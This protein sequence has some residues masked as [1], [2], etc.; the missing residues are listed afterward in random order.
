MKLDRTRALVLVGLLASSCVIT[1]EDD[2]DDKENPGE[3]GAPGEG[4]SPATT[5]GK[6]STGG[7][8]AA[9]DTSDGGVSGA[10]D[11]PSEGGAAGA[12]APSEEGGSGG[13]AS[14]TGGTSGGNSGTGGATGGKASSTGGAPTDEGLGGEGGTGEE[15]GVCSDAEG[16]YPGCEGIT[17]DPSC[18]GLDTFQIGKCESAPTYFKPRIA[19]MIQY[20]IVDQLPLERCDASLTYACADLAIQDSCPDDDEALDACVT[21]LTSCGEVETDTCLVYLSAMTTIG[22]EQTV[23]CMEEGLFCDLYSCAEGL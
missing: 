10:G 23:A 21:I 7:S 22:K 20:C 14:G 17:V 15:P 5:G 19:E 11:S 9:G 16:D 18:E 3:A 2:D 8:S 13:E 4:G 1:T 6:A 12:P